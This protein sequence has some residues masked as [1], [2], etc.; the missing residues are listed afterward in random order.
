MHYSGAL[1][2]LHPSTISKSCIPKCNTKHCAISEYTKR[3]SCTI[4][5]CDVC[6]PQQQIYTAN[7]IMV[8]AWHGTKLYHFI[9][10]WRINYRKMTTIKSKS[11]R[12]FE[13]NWAAKSTNVVQKNNYHNRQDTRKGT[14]VPNLQP[15]VHRHKISVKLCSKFFLPA[16]YL[17]NGT[18]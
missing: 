1:L 15:T 4:H 10:L 16:V 12:G 18:M 9:S 14:K 13:K 5:I 6:I 8:M 11:A 17:L 7:K 3:N 2:F